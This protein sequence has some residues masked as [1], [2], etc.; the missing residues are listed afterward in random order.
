MHS[1]HVCQTTCLL[2][3]CIVKH[4]V[5]PGVQPGHVHALEAAHSLVGSMPVREEALS[6]L[7]GGALGQSLA[8]EA[9]VAL[10]GCSLPPMLQVIPQLPH[11]SARPRSQHHSFAI[12]SAP[13]YRLH[14]F[15][16]LMP[17]LYSMFCSLR[18]WMFAVTGGWTS[19]K[20]KQ[21]GLSTRPGF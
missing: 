3:A 11:L 20:C 1:Q 19:D 18:C 13:P 14:A 7:K 12:C 21:P 6:L 15:G 4:Q 2:G 8:C 16:V 9:Q 17:V 5:S 10:P